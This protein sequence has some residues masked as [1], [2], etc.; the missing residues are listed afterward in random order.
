MLLPLKMNGSVIVIGFMCLAG[1]HDNVKSDAYGNFEA[2]ETIVSAEANGK[3]LQFKADEGDILNENDTI[4]YIDATQLNLQQ[5]QLF[6]SSEA[7]KA[8]VQDIQSQ[9]DV[10]LEQKRNILRERSRLES[11]LK[12]NAATQKQWDD[13]NGELQLTEK[14]IIATRKQIETANHAIISQVE[15]LKEQIKSVQDRIAKSVIINPVNGQVLTKYIEESEIVSY[16]RPLYSIANLSEMILRIYVSGEQLAKIHT[17]QEV[18][19]L[20]DRSEKENRS[21]QGKVS[22]ISSR[23]EFTPKIIQTKKERV[24][25]VYAVKVIVKND[26]SLKIGMPGEVNF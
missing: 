12:E 6:A 26:G 14:R 7:L 2:V 11:M 25:M 22:W 13:M 3:L 8:Q 4:G 15:P 10:L 19:V 21:L 18:G 1:C 24:S 5:R 23:A 9:L 17:G 20:I 16:G